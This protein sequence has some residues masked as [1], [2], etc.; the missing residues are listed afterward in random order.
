MLLRLV[1]RLQPIIL[2]L[3]LG[4]VVWILY[5]QWPTLRDYPWRLHSG[6]LAAAVFLTATVW[7]VEI[8]I[9]VRLIEL[10]GGKRLGLLPAIRIWFLS[11]VVRYIPGNVWQ[12]LSLTLYAQRRGIAPESTI[13]SILLFQVLILI[14]TLPIAVLFA[15]WDGSQ[16]ILSRFMGPTTPWLLGALVLAAVLLLIRSDWLMALINW[17]LQ[18]MGRPSL[19]TH[20]DRGKLLLL[21]LATTVHWLI[22][23]AAFAAFT[24]AVVGDGISDRMGVVVHLISSFAIAYAIGFLSF[25]TPSGFGVREGAFYLLLV[26]RIDGAVVTVIALGIRAWTTAGE[27][28]IALMSAPFERGNAPSADDGQ[29]VA[30]AQIRPIATVAA[31]DA[32]PA[33]AGLRRE[34]T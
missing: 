1:H 12:P 16:S 6:W 10:V 13:T 21:T 29:P 20:L 18:R 26:P 31:A 17:A 3:A 19:S 7:V 28:I 24:F 22:W 34:P 2:V 23:G 25:V 9:W 15:V 5:R 32:P 27:L 11:A 30:S 14:T 8:W 33:P 4:A